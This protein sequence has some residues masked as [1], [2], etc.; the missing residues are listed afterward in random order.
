MFTWYLQSNTVDQQRSN[1]EVAA[2][3]KI[4]SFYTH[5][6]GLWQVHLKNDSRK[7]AYGFKKRKE[8]KEKFRLTLGW[9]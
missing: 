3:I 9:D 4:G 6:S 8:Q 1:L 2:P 7:L 5:V